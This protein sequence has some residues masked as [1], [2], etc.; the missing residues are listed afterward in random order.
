MALISVFADQ[1]RPDRV[2]RYEDIVAEL[3]EKARKGDEAWHW[4]AHQVGF[5]PLARI[6]YTSAH[7]DHADV[8]KHGDPRALFARVFGEK[9]G[10]KKLGE[11]TACQV[12][13]ERTLGLLR[14]DLS[15]AQ[16]PG[17]VVSKLSSVALVR[18]RP[19]RQSDVEELLRKVAEAIP[20][21]GESARI[22]GVQ[23]LTGDMAVYWIVRSL[24]SLADLD[25]QAFGRDLLVKAYGEEEGGR[26]FETDAVDR[27]ERE[28][29][30]YREDLSNPIG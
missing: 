4:T 29:T 16:E 8:E 15:Y 13:S 28:I 30:V 20:K 10:R 22:A 9:E 24:D 21:A 23:A 19:G 25:R 3:A 18:A 17:A 26:A 12:S 1:I 6:Y 27:L 7:E 14:P 2:Q 11:A 5:G